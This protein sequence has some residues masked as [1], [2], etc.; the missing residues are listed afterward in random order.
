MA[1]N[2]TIE[3]MRNLR[4]ANREHMQA[5]V[6]S[7]LATKDPEFYKAHSLKAM[8]KRVDLYLDVIA[9]I[10]ETYGMSTTLLL[11]VVMYADKYVREQGIHHNRVFHTLLTSAVCTIKYWNDAFMEYSELNYRISKT[12]KCPLKLLNDTE[13]GF[14]HALKWDLS[15]QYEEVEAFYHKSEGTMSVSELVEA[16]CGV[17]RGGVSGGGVEGGKACAQM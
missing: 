11:A 3:D 4:D 7:W 15:L 10:L 5:V 2:S 12:W 16:H 8:G 9:S 6:V 13:R 1:H 17:V 14:L